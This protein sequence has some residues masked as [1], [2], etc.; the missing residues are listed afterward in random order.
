MSN[1]VSK[2]HKSP[3]A[4]TARMASNLFLARFTK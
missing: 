3:G 4:T 2:S 1:I